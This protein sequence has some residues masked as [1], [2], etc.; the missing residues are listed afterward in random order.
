MNVCMYV[1]LL[2]VLVIKTMSESNLE[3]VYRLQTKPGICARSL[4]TLSCRA[5]SPA[6]STLCFDTGSLAEPIMETC[7]YGILMQ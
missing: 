4:G 3:K 6:P 5:I 2:F 1:L 7:M